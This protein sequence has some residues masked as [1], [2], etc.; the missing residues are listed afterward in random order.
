MKTIHHLLCVQNTQLRALPA[1]KKLTLWN[2]GNE[3]NED[4]ARQQYK[5][6]R[7]C[8]RCSPEN[9]PCIFT[10]KNYSAKGGAEGCID[11]QIDN[12]I[13]NPLCNRND[14]LVTK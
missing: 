12:Q 13:D 5:T 1:Q 7:G 14:T 10:G 6:G 2:E 3:G 9:T 8:F 4:Q 11:N